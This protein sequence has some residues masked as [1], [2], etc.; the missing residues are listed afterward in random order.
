[1]KTDELNEA[2]IFLVSV[3]YTDFRKRYLEA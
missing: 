2:Y 1:M 3:M